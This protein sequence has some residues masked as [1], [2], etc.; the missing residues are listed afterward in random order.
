MIA[1]GDTAYALRSGRALEWSFAGYAGPIAFD[2]FAGRPLR[3][4]TPA[5][6]IAVLRQGFAPAW[7]P[8]ADT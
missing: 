7:H 6:T 8:T 5:T 1:D 4:L 2:R 3:V